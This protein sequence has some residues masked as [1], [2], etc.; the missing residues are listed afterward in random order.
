M[1]VHIVKG[2][3]QWA[4]IKILQ[5]TFIGMKK[6]LSNPMS[7]FIVASPVTFTEVSIFSTSKVSKGT[8][9]I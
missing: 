9:G 1:L 5:C 2:H 3:F 7:V 8:K 4:M 6:C